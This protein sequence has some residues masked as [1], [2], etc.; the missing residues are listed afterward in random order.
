MSMNEIIDAQAEVL[1][2]LMA[3]PKLM[4]CCYLVDNHFQGKYKVI[5]AGVKKSIAENGSVMFDQLARDGADIDLVL[6]C[7]ETVISGDMG[8]FNHLQGYI[9][10]KWYYV[11]ISD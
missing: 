4:K 5:F 8:R 7:Q 2:M 11:K 9:N 10:K 3:Y 6:K 1:G